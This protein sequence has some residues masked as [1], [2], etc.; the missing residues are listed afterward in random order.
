MSATGYDAIVVGGGFA[1]VTAARELAGRGRRTLLLE[2]RDRLGGRTWTT[3]ME[4]ATI[5]L[6]GGWIHWREPHVW[7]EVTRYGIGVVEDDWKFDAAI[8][9]AP[10]SRH[11]PQAS[12]ARVKELFER[13][14]GASREALPHPYDPLLRADR[15]AALDRLSMQDRLD[16]L[17]LPKEDEAW[18]SGLLF[19]IAGSSLAG[20]GLVPVLRWLALSDWN[21][22]HWYDTNKVRPVGGMAA[23]V[24]AMCEDGGFE[25]ASS[26]P[27]RAVV[28]D[29]DAVRIETD[30]DAYDASAVV[31]AVPVNVWPTIEFT[32]GLPESHLAAAAEGIG[33]PHQDKVWIRARGEIGRIFGQLPAPAPLN[34]FWTYEMSADSQLIIGINASPE[35]DVS[36]EESVARL[37]RSYVPEIEEVV[38][39]RGHAWGSDPYARGGNTCH[40]P[41]QLTKYLADLQRPRGRL[42]F[43]GADIASGWAGYV[44]GAIESGIRAARDCRLI[45]EGRA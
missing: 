45:L 10:A 36:D 38:G 32:P 24:E 14:V 19:E 27:V 42:T 39:V 12:F 23:L 1:G 16:Q 30:A 37:I 8:G 21:V 4:G 11:D 28:V 40:R 20:A 34:F 26:S 33:K 25:V 6:G 41:G 2:A 31:V 13:F 15:L 35:L 43:A 9:G 44:D 7:A 29:G 22:D 18:L 3:E 17:D 5:E